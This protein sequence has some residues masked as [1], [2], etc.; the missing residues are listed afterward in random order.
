[1]YL[2][3]ISETSPPSTLGTSGGCVQANVYLVPSPVVPL[4]RTS[5]TPIL[6]KLKFGVSPG[7]HPDPPN[8]CGITPK[9]STSPDLVFMV[10][11]FMT[12][13][14]QV[15]SQLAFAKPSPIF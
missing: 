2:F 5:D 7:I 14:E 9:D 10:E 8:E 15:L 11:T 3:T 13:S 1:M 6:P 4:N 12:K